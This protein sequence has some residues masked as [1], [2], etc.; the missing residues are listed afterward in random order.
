M[1]SFPINTSPDALKKASN[2][3]ASLLHEPYI[4]H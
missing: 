4:A 1:A 3:T 2:L